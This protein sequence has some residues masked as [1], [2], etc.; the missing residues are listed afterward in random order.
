MIFLGLIGKIPLK[1]GL[2]VEFSK[3]QGIICKA[4]VA[5]SLV[6]RLIYIKDKGSSENDQRRMVG[7]LR[8]NSS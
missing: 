5:C 2:R 7:G 3:T 8:V 1:I 4:N 6:C